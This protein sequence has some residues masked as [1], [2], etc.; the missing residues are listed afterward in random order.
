MFA[1]FHLGSIVAFLLAMWVFGT[2]RPTI[3]KA[4]EAL[5]SIFPFEK[6]WSVLSF[7]GLSGLVLLTT[8]LWIW[9]KIYQTFVAPY[10]QKSILEP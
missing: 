5:G 10:L 4:L 2:D 6:T 3:Q 8:Y 7:F 9:K 1:L